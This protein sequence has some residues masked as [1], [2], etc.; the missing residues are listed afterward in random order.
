[1]TLLRSCARQADWRCRRLDDT[2]TAE[3]AKVA[4]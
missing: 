3:L 2:Q 1:V 4:G